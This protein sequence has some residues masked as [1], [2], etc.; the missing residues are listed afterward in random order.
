MDEHSLFGSMI[1]RHLTFSGSYEL[2]LPEI[3]EICRLCRRAKHQVPVTLGRSFLLSFWLQ[4][5]FRVLGNCFFCHGGCPIKAQLRLGPFLFPPFLIVYYASI[6][7]NYV[8]VYIYI[9]I[10][11]Y[12]R[13]IYIYMYICIYVYMYTCIYVYMYICIY[14]HMYICIYVYKYI[15]IYVYMYTC[16][17]VYIFMYEYMNICKYVLYICI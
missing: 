10:I 11:T 1:I 3:I 14:V 5:F 13:I 7:I 12:I 6:T 8:C 2:K 17:Y 4:G 9:L 15:C 16:I